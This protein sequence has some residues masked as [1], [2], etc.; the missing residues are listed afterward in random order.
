MEL[1]TLGDTFAHA[2]FLEGGLGVVRGHAV[3]ADGSASIFGRDGDEVVTASVPG[4]VFDGLANCNDD[5]H[6]LLGLSTSRLSPFTGWFLPVFIAI[7]ICGVTPTSVKNVL[8]LRFGFGI[9]DW[10]DYEEDFITTG[11]FIGEKKLVKFYVTILLK[12][13]KKTYAAAAKMPPSR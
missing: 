2:A 1:Y 7:G 8:T 4:E 11:I 12:T 6:A 10:R 13:V 9:E 3:D 5:H